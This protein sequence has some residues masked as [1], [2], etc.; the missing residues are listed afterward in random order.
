MVRTRTRTRAVYLPCFRVHARTQGA[1][2]VAVSRACQVR[3]ACGHGVGIL[4]VTLLS[5][6]P[7]PRFDCACGAAKASAL[8]D[9]AQE[10][11]DANEINLSALKGTLRSVLLF[12]KG[13]ARKHLS[14]ALVHGL[15]PSRC[16]ADAPP[17]FPHGPPSH[18]L[19]C[20]HARGICPP[21][22]PPPTLRSGGRVLSLIG[23]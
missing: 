11:A 21:P 16:L 7:S 19:F 14:K 9:K 12:F 23:F 10:F 5:C 15:A 3:G 4:C 13:A 8:V 2:V 1:C 22:P 6:A 18:R 20:M 17:V